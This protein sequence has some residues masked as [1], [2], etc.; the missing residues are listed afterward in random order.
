MTSPSLLLRRSLLLALVPW[1]CSTPSDAGLDA[2]GGSSG[3]SSPQTSGAES[4]SGA[5]NVDS[6]GDAS[7]SSGSGDSGNDTSVPGEGLPCEVDAVLATYCRS[8]H[9][10]PLV[11]TTFAMLTRDDML[12]PAPSDPATTVGAKSVERMQSDLSPMPPLPATPP[13]A[14]ELAIIADWVGAGMPAGDCLPDDMPSPFDAE[15]VCTSDMWWTGGNEE[16][17]RMHPGVACDA[18]HSGAKGGE[19]EGPRLLIAGTVYPSGHEPDDCYGV[20]SILVQVTD[21]NDQVVE[22]HTNSAGNF[23]LED[24]EA[25]AG[26]EAPYLVKVV[27]DVGERVMAMPVDN[28]DCNVCH[29]QDGTMDAPGRIVAPW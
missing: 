1:G 23:M 21:A 3:A 28:G 8:C 25:P 5:S 11:G 22:L 10:D 26:F 15:P 2:S 9:G 20:S 7:G 17:P 6:S 16:D 27:S 4:S 14:D 24:E 13:T 12:A 29:T 18:C 19:E